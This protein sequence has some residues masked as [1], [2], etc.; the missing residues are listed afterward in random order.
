MLVSG[1]RAMWILVMFDLPV[2]KKIQRKRATEF[3][4]KLLKD[5]F[6]M[7]QLSV[8]LKPA[9]SEENAA[10]HLNRV[11]NFL[12]PEGQVRIMKITDKQF[13]RMICFQGETAHAPE[14]MPR[15][16]ELF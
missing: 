14:K 8:Y 2:K 4:K 1:Y 11:R 7:I 9:P 10:V 15:Q 3:R 5:G 16:L 12:P 6:T 13:G